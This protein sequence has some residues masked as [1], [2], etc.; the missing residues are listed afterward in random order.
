MLTPPCTIWAPERFPGFIAGT[1]CPILTPPWRL[2]I[3]CEI[4][5][6]GLELEVADVNEARPEFCPTCAEAVRDPELVITDG[7]DENTF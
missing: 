5:V 3:G 2:A 4:P 1:C 7:P 6:F